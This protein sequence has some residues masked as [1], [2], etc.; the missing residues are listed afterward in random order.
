MKKIIDLIK[1]L[2]GGGSL[3]EKAIELKQL[4]SAV[5]EEVATVKEVVAEKTAEVKAVETKVAN[6]IAPNKNNKPNKKK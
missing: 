5:K 1:A 4:E 3:A 6:K 2:L